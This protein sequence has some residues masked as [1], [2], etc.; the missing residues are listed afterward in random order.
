[1]KGREEEHDKLDMASPSNKEVDMQSDMEKP[2]P[3][4]PPSGEGGQGGGFQLRIRR[5]CKRG[6]L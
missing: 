6:R 3:E 5:L 2:R 4:W 1:M